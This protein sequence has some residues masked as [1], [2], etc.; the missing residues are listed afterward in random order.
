MKPALLAHLLSLSIGASFPLQTQANIADRTDVQAFIQQMA[1]R[2]GFAR[3]ELEKLFR[4]VDIQDKVLDAISKPYEA[5]PW[6]Q[7]RKLFLT[8]ARIQGGLTFWANNQAA[9][10][11]ASR[12][13]GVAPE[14]IVA[15]IGIETSYGQNTGN[16]RVIDALSTLTFN[17]PKRADFFRKELESFLVLSKQEGIDPLIPKGS[18]AGA[19]GLPQF[20][21]SSYLNFAADLDGDHKR[22]IWSNPADAIGSV[23]N[24]FSH[25][26]W[27]TGEAVAFPASIEGD[28]YHHLLGKDL[29]PSHTLTQLM[30]AGIR[31][32]SKPSLPSTTKAK[33]LALDG[34]ASTE[35]WLTLQNFYAITRYNHS[36]LYA[37]AAHQLSQELVARRTDKAATRP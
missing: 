19:M 34:E 25:H 18:Y 1:K 17:Y 22:N 15:I 27:Q 21:P 5:K 6:Y 8:E 30:S 33:L 36:P 2:P 3:G 4:Q 9:L 24:Y 12:R 16:Y 11:D 14:I 23:A 29:R 10:A 32:P 20:M 37:M 26:G 35:Y 13:Y 7:Y 28:K 31:L